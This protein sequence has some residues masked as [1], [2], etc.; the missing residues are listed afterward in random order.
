VTPPIDPSVERVFASYPRDVSQQLLRVRKLIFDVAA[1][2]PGVGPL[3]ETL[4]WGEPSY[5]TEESGSGSTIRLAPDRASGGA[6]VHFIC[7]TKLVD[8]FRGL[9][10]DTLR[11]AGNRSILVQEESADRRAALR[12]C[13]ALALTH[14]SRKRAAGARAA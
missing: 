8:A 12:H 1:A 14:H 9:Y 5:L 11:Y 10:P 13:I 6:A 2:T 7:T 3:R 4:R